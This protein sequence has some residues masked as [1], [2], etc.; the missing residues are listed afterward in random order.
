MSLPKISVLKQ[1]SV[2]IGRQALAHVEALNPNEE[3]CYLASL[4][5]SQNEDK[6]QYRLHM[7]CEEKIT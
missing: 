5:F 2:A 4:C 6:K 1:S 3:Q 7:P